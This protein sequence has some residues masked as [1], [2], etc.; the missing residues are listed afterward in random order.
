M[1][2]KKQLIKGLYNWVL[3]GIIIVSLILINIISSF[4]Y[5][6]FDTTSDQRYS[7]SEGTIEYLENSENFKT[8]LNLKIYLAGNLPAELK[9][10]KNAIE[11]KLNEFKEIAGNK[12][13][14]QFIDPNVGTEGEQKELFDHIF[15][16]GK[17]VLPMNLVYM[18]DGSQTQMMLWPGAIINYGGSSVQSIQLLPGSKSDRPYQLNTMSDLIQNS[19][20]NL[21]YMLISSLRRATLEKKPNIAFLHGHGE[22]TFPETQRI[23]AL[24]SPYFSVD[25]IT[26]NDSLNALDK[27]TGLIIA[28]PRS[29]F[30]DKD[31]YLIDQFV[32]KGGR[33][34]CFM[35]QLY[36]N[37][38]TL[39]T[40]GETH[41][42]R[43]SS[44]R[45]DKMLFDY[46]LKINDNFVMD[47]HSAPT[48]VEYSKQSVIPWFYN[49][50]ATPTKHAIARNVEPV[51]LPYTSEIQF[52][53][54]NP[55]IALTPILTSSS[56]STASGMAP[57]LNLG[58]YQN[59]GKSPELVPNP[60]SET[61]KKCLAGL[62]EGM[63][64]SHF[65]NRIVESFVNNPE[66]HYYEKSQSEGKVMLIG[67]G[68]FIMNSYDSTPSRTGNSY[69]YRPKNVND[70]QFSQ[71]LINLKIP[72][73]FGNQ[74]FFQNM[75]DYMMGDNSVLD[76]RSRQI[77]I[78]EMDKDR[79]KSH[80]GM[81]RMLNIGIPILSIL[82]LA[83]L[84]IYMRRRKYTQ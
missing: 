57:L 28:R 83:I 54:N 56:N 1:A 40:K 66:I 46:G 17:G 15:A 11:N 31:L 12:I 49:V 71:E 84:F 22:L 5:K 75:T 78:H 26:L 25:D 73:F 24:M 3:L 80:A 6:R 34:M 13:E 59:Y 14:Y 62:A 37:E 72:H 7:L 10:F 44:L 63:F 50:L 2:E 68:R 30:S 27:L 8:R 60:E 74:E 20:N 18:K 42:T 76:I 79:V 32:M 9:Y 53:G 36:F 33:L 65:R 23:R 61:N 51:F 70:L 19:I 45:L 69:Q 55:E 48:Q 41:T 64:Q 52:V 4:V 58:I 21:E 29:T 39:K 67:N 16:Q 47:A 38:D 82:V 35:D 81:Y 77:D 43:Y